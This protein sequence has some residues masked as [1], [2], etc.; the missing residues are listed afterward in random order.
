M[1]GHSKWANI[2]GTKGAADKRRAVAFSR[3]ARLITVATKEGGGPDATKNFKLRV[4]IEKARAVNMPKENIERA[5]AKGAGGSGGEELESV[6]YEALMVGGRVGILIECATDNKNRTNGVVKT[7]LTKQGATPAAS[8]AVS[9]MFERRGVIRVGREIDESLQLA[10]ID[11]GAVDFSESTIYTE[12]EA[13]WS[14]IR[15]LDEVG[16]AVEYSELEWVPSGAHV[17][18]SAEERAT[19]ER[20]IAALE[21]TDDVES[22]YTNAAI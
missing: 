10:L 18:L 14:V 20:I 4:A 8:G 12:V 13:F 3:A 22:V 16:V 2:Q 7:V 21:D 1:S 9:W 17:E 11:V 5:I 15:A 19:V 6:L